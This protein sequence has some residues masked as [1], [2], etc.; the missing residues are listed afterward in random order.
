MQKILSETYKNTNLYS[1]FCVW[2]DIEGKE[3]LG[4]LQ[5]EVDITLR[6]IIKESSE[7]GEGS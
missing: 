2:F 4:G 7:N 5:L 6:T 1:V 3:G